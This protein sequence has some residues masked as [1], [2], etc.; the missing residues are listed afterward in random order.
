MFERGLLRPDRFSGDFCRVVF[1]GTP[2]AGTRSGR[3]LARWRYG[4]RMLGDVGGSELL[5]E[6]PRT[7]RWSAQLGVIAGTKPHG[8]GRFIADLDGPND[9]T[10][11]VTE[12]RMEGITAHRALPVSH[13]G[14][15]VSP[16]VVRE[17]AT[18]LDRGDFSGR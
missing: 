3:A 2:S 14:M 4:R 12:T 17:I 15:V 5:D 16:E 13:M 7:W 18:F 10:V 6:R 9:G 8:L 1:L 11:A